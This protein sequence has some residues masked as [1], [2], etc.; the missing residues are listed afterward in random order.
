[1]ITQCITTRGLLK[2]CMGTDHDPLRTLS[3]HECEIDDKG[4]ADWLLKFIITDQIAW[5]IISM[6]ARAV[7]G[8]RATQLEICTI[9]FAVLAIG[10]YIANWAKPKDT[11][12]HCYFTLTNIRHC[13]GTEEPGS[14]FIDILYRPSGTRNLG[15]ISRI[16]NDCVGVK[17]SV[18]LMSVVMAIST[19][20]F[21][22]LAW[23]F[24][25]PTNT[26]RLIWRIASLLSRA[27]LTIALMTCFVGSLRINSSIR[28]T[29]ESF[30]SESNKF[31][32]GY[33]SG[34]ES[35][36]FLTTSSICHGRLS[37]LSDSH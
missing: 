5:L 1:M 18:P 33:R 29:L 14:S 22:A 2:C 6:I 20:G 36:G 25:F 13:T 9:A 24:E 10:T 21:G 23:N 32:A 35:R 30:K 34:P 19:L 7:R 28:L 16:K 37:M 17:G 15:F 31:R 11:Q 27:I 8:L 26:E 3:S 4:K 12:V